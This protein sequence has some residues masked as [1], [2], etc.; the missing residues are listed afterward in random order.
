MSVMKG[1]SMVTWKVV[2]SKKASV[3]SQVG[4]GLEEALVCVLSPKKRGRKARSFWGEG[5]PT[6]MSIFS[7]QPASTQGA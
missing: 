5:I 4:E 7:V 3:A 6:S 2:C 1:M